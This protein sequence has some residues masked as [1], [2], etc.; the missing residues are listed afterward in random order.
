MRVVGNAFSAASRFLSQ[1]N[2]SLWK[3]VARRLKRPFIS[4]RACAASLEIALIGVSPSLLHVV[5]RQREQL[6]PFPRAS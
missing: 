4:L 3:F 1:E 6:Q 2:P 5:P